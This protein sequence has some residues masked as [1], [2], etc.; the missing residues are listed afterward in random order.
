MDT[1]QFA[2]PGT[3]QTVMMVA[4]AP[5]G[6]VTARAMP[7]ES[8]TRLLAALFGQHFITVENLVYLN[9]VRVCPHYQ[10][11]EWNFYLLSNGGFYMAPLAVP[12]W[13]VVYASKEYQGALSSNAV[14]MLV[15]AMTLN[16]LTS[17]RDGELMMQMQFR[18]RD[19]IKQQPG[20]TVLCEL[21]D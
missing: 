9:M 10:G 12:D 21:L 1:N 18:L 4:P 14:G 5:G 2:K 6:T 19:F 15:S 13:F 17:W 8:R 16:Q 7:R 11:G 20:A 3:C